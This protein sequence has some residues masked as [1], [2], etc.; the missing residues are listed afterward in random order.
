VATLHKAKGLEWP[1][2]FLVGLVDGRFPARGRREQLAVPD[3]LLRGVFPSGD[4]HVQEERRLFYVGMTRAR[5]ELVLSHALD[6]GGKRTRRVSPF[7]L[8]ALDL[9]AGTTPPARASSPIERLAAFEATAAERPAVAA[10]VDPGEPLV[11]SFYGVDD[12]LTCPLK[13]RYVHVMRVPIAPHHAIVYG[14][15]LHAAVSEFH[16]RHARG[17]VMTEEGLIGAFE[18][19]WS[20]E[21]FVSRE[22]EEAR[23]EAGR[24]AL[25]RFRAEQLAPGAV[26][27]A[28]VER[29]F[30]FTLDGDRVRGRMDRIDISPWRADGRPRPGRWRRRRGRRGARL[31]APA[32]RVVIADYQGSDVASQRSR[33]R[34]RVA[35]AD[36]LRHGWQAQTGRLRTPWP[37][38]PSRAS[39]GWPRWTRRGSRRGSPISARRPRGSG[40][41]GS[42]PRRRTWPAPGAPFARS[43][44]RASPDEVPVTGPTG[45]MESRPSLAAITF[46]FGNTLVPVNLSA[47]EE[48]VGALADAAARRFGVPRDAFL[49]AWR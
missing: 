13:Y 14:A 21:G 33:M 17:D 36:D 35:P 3:A 6:Y 28:Y 44:R 1:V 45:A 34:A 47:L 25:R 49:G 7:V 48:V 4:P 29:E 2:V 20:N 18:T 11:L 24:A 19:A 40:R 22:H 15:A 42:R 31:P 41:A 43:A 26:V 10:A 5:D 27:P 23:L 12:Y 46:D 38:L 39:S 8:E 37:L 30:S 9:P 16:R 32:R